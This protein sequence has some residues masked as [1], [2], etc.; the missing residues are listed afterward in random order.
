MGWS[1]GCPGRA[2]ASLARRAR[3]TAGRRDVGERPA[4][5]FVQ[6]GARGLGI[7]LRAAGALL[8]DE[9]GQA[10]AH[11]VVRGEAEVCRD[12]LDVVALEDAGGALGGDDREERVLLDQDAVAGGQRERAAAPALADD[13]GDGGDGRL[14]QRVERGRDLARDAVRL[15][16]GA[17]VGA[18][19][20][21]S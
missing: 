15:R 13:A 2:P 7:G 5:G 17:G 12:G 10:A 8:D 6:Q 18:M 14:A 4:D 19:R 3:G 9:V 1:Q 11:E 20:S 16:R 21:A